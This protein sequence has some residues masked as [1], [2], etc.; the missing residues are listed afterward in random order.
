M[1]YPIQREHAN[2]YTIDTV[3]VHVFND[4]SFI[5]FKKDVSVL[6]INTYF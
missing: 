4:F 1:I 6:H 5:L 2:I 3:S